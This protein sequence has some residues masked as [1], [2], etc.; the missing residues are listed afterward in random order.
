MAG[1]RARAQLEQGLAG[2]PFSGQRA[3]MQGRNVIHIR[4][5]IHGT[6]PLSPRE[7][8]LVDQPAF[9][10]LRNIK[11]LGF[12]D[13]AFPGAS[14]SR[15]S[16]SLG[17]MWVATRVFDRLFSPGDL[18]DPVRLRFRQAV[19]LAMLFHDVG[20]APLSHTTE[21]LMPPVGELG[22]G[23]LTGDNVSRRASHEDY[24]LKIILD[25][26]LGEAIR[27]LFSE[28][29]LLPEDVVELIH[30]ERPITRFRHGGIDYAPVLRQI[31]SS[32]C[33]ADRMDYLQR[34]S[35][36][37]GVNYG[38]FDADWLIDNV[39]PV[40]RDG[41][42]YL[43]LKSR[44]VFSFEDFL[45]SRYHMFATVYLHYTPVIF[46]KMLARYFEECSGEFSL[47]ADVEKYIQLDD[48]DLSMALRKSNNAWA[49]RIVQRR[50]FTLLNE[51]NVDRPL[52]DEGSVDHGV[53]RSRLLEAGIDPIVTQSRSILSKYWNVEKKIPIYVVTGTHQ[54]V[55]LERYTALYIRYEEPAQIGRIYVAQEKR[56]QAREILSGLIADE[57]ERQ[58]PTAPA[59]EA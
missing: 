57:Q 36:Y 11:Q 27:E 22:L 14:H 49:Q 15:Y 24:T 16:H 38:K 45:L 19:R 21:M 42:I 52:S 33:D 25:S 35:F 6:L 43:G 54:V 10:R 34:D 2:V 31:I 44:A 50:P 53:L 39:V 8:R 3:A 48:I 13:L 4:D 1:Q 7:I 30:G 37:S 40:Q 55:P 23:A 18:P 46:E 56:A 41:A 29:G 5:P 20:H 58:A 9:Q 47:P 12:A 59:A 28:D 32:E 26:P 17:A 51:A